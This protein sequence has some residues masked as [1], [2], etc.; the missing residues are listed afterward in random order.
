V[1]A[2]QKIF[3]LRLATLIGLCLPAL[4]LAWRWYNGDLE[5][6]PVTVATHATGDW[7][8]IF[9]MLSLAMTPARALFDWMPLVQIRR[10]IGVAAALYAG[11]HFSIYVLDQKWNLVV[12]A[13][14]I[15]RRFYLTIG[16]V[17]LLA[18]VILAITST[19]GWQKRLRRNWK[20]LHWLIYPAA[21]I[22]IVHFFIQSKVKIGEPAFTAGLFAW[23]MLWRVV[24]AK[25]Q[26]SYL[27]LAL[28]AVSAT[29]AAVVFET[30]WYGLVN[31]VDPVRVLAA[32]IDP[33]LAFRPAQKV[34]IASL[35]VIAAVALRRL[36]LAANKLWTKRYV[37]STIPTP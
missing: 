4:E 14:E 23:L 32:N 34:L 12:V 9:L 36:T 28:L 30:A 15:I 16:F 13:T 35:L 29:L 24:P 20:R 10:R 26:R 2:K 6:R 21:F 3:W 18:L 37:Q 1:T 8:V 25:M 7:A 19:D 17:A 27:G 5:P 31:G 33:D 22:A 11:A